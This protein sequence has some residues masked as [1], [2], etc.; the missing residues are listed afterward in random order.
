MF[1]F[2]AIST[3][4]AGITASA[5]CPPNDLML[6]CGALGDATRICEPGGSSL[7]AEGC[8]CCR[9]GFAK[10][11]VTTVA[12][13]Y[14]VQTSNM[15]TSASRNSQVSGSAYA[16]V[17]PTSTCGAFAC[18]VTG[19]SELASSSPYSVS[20]GPIYGNSS[21]FPSLTSVSECVSPSPT[22]NFHLAAARYNGSPQ[23]GEFVVQTHQTLL[24]DKQVKQ[25]LPPECATI[26]EQTRGYFYPAESTAAIG[27]IY[28]VD[29]INSGLP[30]SVGVS[31]GISIE[32]AVTI[33]AE[34]NACG[35]FDECFESSGPML[36]VDRLITV[37]V[38][39]GYVGGGWTYGI[40]GGRV[41]VYSDGTFTKDGVFSDGAFSVSNTG[42]TYTLSGCL[43]CSLVS[44]EGRIPLRVCINS[45]SCS[46]SGS[47]MDLNGDG[48]ICWDDL[49]LLQILADQNSD[50][51]QIAGADLNSDAVVDSN[52]LA[53]L[54]SYLV[55]NNPC[56]ADMNCD[57]FLDGFDYDRFTEWFECGLAA[58]DFNGDGFI[59]GFD[60]DGYI[61]AF[62]N[63]T[64]C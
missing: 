6:D 54:R 14:S 34:D 48:I 32:S 31:V 56:D 57:G 43:T 64:G 30:G 60:Y 41:K 39:I 38:A 8:P 11:E 58:A 37:P 5:Y 59:D 63:G 7:Y 45:G 20:E 18:E 22:G 17:I 21:S 49:N 53:A 40:F 27:A 15:G 33:P 55:A 26:D 29:R 10:Y 47:M 61:E 24:Y 25:T 13:R 50:F 4:L 2:T 36:L 62:E 51:C 52:D 35:D 42:T 23:S 16:R 44:D 28:E 19:Y 12:V 46:P 1:C 3:A 9:R